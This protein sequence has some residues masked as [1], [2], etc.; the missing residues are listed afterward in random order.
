[1]PHIVLTAEQLQVIG[2]AGS[3]VEV[4]GPGNEPL[5]C[6]TVFS[7]AER[8][9]I[10]RFKHGNGARGP[11]IP[12]DRVQAF[13]RK[14]HETADREGIDERKVQELLHRVRGGELL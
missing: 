10:A 4:L 14:L 8:E 9:A 5:G 12:S 1:V 2:T 7:P 6:L 3:P 11:G 13:L